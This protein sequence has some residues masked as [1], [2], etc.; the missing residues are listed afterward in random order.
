MNKKIIALLIGLLVLSFGS[1]SFAATVVTPVADF[2]TSL[3]SP[4]TAAATQLTLVS[5]TDNDGT[6]LVIGQRYG[7]TIDGDSTSNKEYVIGTAST[8]NRIV[9]LVRGVSVVTGTSTVSDNAKAHG[10]G[11][12]IEITNAPVLLQLAGVIN[13]TIDIT[14]VIRYATTTATSTIASDDRNLVNVALLNSTAFGSIPAAS[15]TAAGFVEL[16]TQV[17]AASSTS[18]NGLTRLILGTNISTSTYNVA[19]APL[20]IVMTQNSGKIDNNFIATS[21]GLFTNMVVTGSFT[22]SDITGSTVFASSSIVAYTSSTTPSTTYTKPANLKYIKVITQGP[23]APTSNSNA[24]AGAGAGAYCVKVIPA[25][26]LGTTETIVVSKYPIATSFGSFVSAGSG[27]A[28]SGNTGN[29]AGGTCTG[30]DIQIPGGSGSDGS[31]ASGAFMSGKVGDSVLG[32]GGGSVFCE[33]NTAVTN[34]ES[35]SGYG[36]GGSGGTDA[37]D[38][39]PSGPSA[40]IG[41]GGAIFIEQFFY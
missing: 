25:S 22:A 26:A 41:S 10:R 36:G 3:S 33:S 13:G 6:T 35:G 27:V 28:S 29:G 9:D 5:F 21:T 31:L 11:A 15:E 4:I 30:G 17:E 19:T 23:G 18:A 2:S 37:C 34:G 14:N 7:F 16:A 38:A 8:S 20:R 24:G 12:L 39:S 40:G 32:K 1:I